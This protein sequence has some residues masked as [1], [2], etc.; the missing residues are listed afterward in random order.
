MRLRNQSERAAGKKIIFKSTITQISSKNFIEL[1]S[2]E[3]FHIAWK[4]WEEEDM[5][6]KLDLI[7]D[8]NIEKL[9]FCK[10]IFI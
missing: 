8:W 5:E 1:M 10:I 9:G 6:S 4:F 7:K 3:K 2:S